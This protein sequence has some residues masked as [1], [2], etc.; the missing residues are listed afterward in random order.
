M[1]LQR[2]FTLVSESPDGSIGSRAVNERCKPK[3]SAP[4]V[5]FASRDAD[6]MAFDLLESQTG[7]QIRQS[8]NAAHR[9]RKSG[10]F[11]LNV[12]EIEVTLENGIRDGPKDARHQGRCGVAEGTV[13]SGRQHGVDVA[14]AEVA[15]ER[16]LVTGTQVYAAGRTRNRANVN[17]SPCCHGGAVWLP[18]EKWSSARLRR[19]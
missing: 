7:F 18:P 3:K 9:G 16:N 4:A 6:R 8:E 17:S 12:R 19:Y 13:V 1:W 15:G 10:G 14:N 5:E 2:S 11:I